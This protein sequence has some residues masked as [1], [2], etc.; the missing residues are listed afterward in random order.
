MAA[1][2]I[3]NMDRSAY[4]AAAF[5]SL[6]ECTGILGPD[7]QVIEMN[8]AG[9]RKF[10]VSR[11][12]ELPE[13]IPVSRIAEA[14][15]EEYRANALAVLAGDADAADRVL[16]VGLISGD[17]QARPIECSMTP[18]KDDSGEIIAVIVTS[19]D[20]SRWQ[21]ALNEVEQSNAILQSILTTIPDAMIAIDEQGTIILFSKMAEQMFGYQ[22]SEILGKSV[23]ILM[24]K[25]YGIS[26]QTFV[27]RY[28]RTGMK[29]IIGTGRALKARHKE[30]TIFPIQASIGEIRVA[31]QRRFTGFFIDLTEKQ[32]TEAQLQT[33]QLELQHA[34]RVSDVGT[35][36]SS[37]AHELNQPLTAIANYLSTGRDIL[38]DL[39]S[40]N[41]HLLQEALNESVAESLR[42]GKIV[43]RLREFV[44]KGDIRMEVLSMADLVNDSK[45]LGLI[46]ARVKGVE[47]SFDIR[48]DINHVLADKVQIQQVM[49]N[50]IRN[51]IEAMDD[52]PVKK[53]SVSAHTAPDNRVEFV[54]QDSGPGI[55]PDVRDRLFA[56]FATT[57]SDGMGLGLSICK[58]IVEAHGGKLV[59]ED[60]PEGGTIFRFSLRKAPKEHP[61][62]E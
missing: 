55:S 19:R 59:F 34:S 53:L 41:V 36:A 15:R 57:K 46:D 35:L 14:D 24:P 49:I 27:D 37:L 25:S 13:G 44:S 17:G 8:P 4:L 31:G 29:Q 26:H 10:G 51:A 7:L 43:R 58:T 38:D 48:P 40:E 42:A 62:A 18:L 23:D 21:D 47:Y 16:R 1:I 30:G 54:V 12:S 22:E 2:G 11:V 5:D 56:P 20:M 28:L 39:K 33:L 32:Q 60:A 3:S 9:L 52:S 6:P 45:T 61:H 50:L